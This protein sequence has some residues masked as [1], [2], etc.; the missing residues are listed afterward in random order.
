MQIFLF[1]Y[2]S[3]SVFYQFVTFFIIGVACRQKNPATRLAAGNY[4]NM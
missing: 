4:I 2:V 3:F 1:L